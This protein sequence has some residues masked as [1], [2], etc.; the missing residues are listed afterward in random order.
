MNMSPRRPALHPRAAANRFI[1]IN[2]AV[3]MIGIAVGVW[4]LIVLLSVMNG[5]RK[6][7]HGISA[8]SRIAILADDNRLDTGGGAE[9][10]R[11]ASARGRHRAFVQAQAMLSNGTGRARRAGAGSCAERKGRGPGAHMRAGS[12]DALKPG[13]FGVCWGDLGRSGRPAR[14]QD[15]ARGATR[16]GDTAGGSRGSSIHGGG[17]VRGGIVDA[18]AGLALVQCTT[19]RRSTRWAKR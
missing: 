11:A 7:W 14:R 3:S 10:R 19:R 15:R 8:W 4:A 13:E 17:R 1:G 5:S 6:K 9:D 12:L 18:D 2:S 16:L